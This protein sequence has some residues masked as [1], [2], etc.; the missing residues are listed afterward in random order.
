MEVEAIRSMTIEEIIERLERLVSAMREGFD[1]CGRMIKEHPDDQRVRVAMEGLQKLYASVAGYLYATFGIGSGVA[2]G[3]GDGIAGNRT[4]GKG[5]RPFKWVS[6][7]K[8][9][10]YWRCP[11]LGVSKKD[12]EALER[13]F[14]SCCALRLS[15]RAVAMKFDVRSSSTPRTEREK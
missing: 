13:D 6:R 8:L 4:R 9:A 14:A 3:L 10:E 12:L 7:A 1:E 5:R 15:E 2:G 11:P